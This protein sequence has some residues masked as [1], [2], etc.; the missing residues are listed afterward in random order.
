MNNEIISEASKKTGMALEKLIRVAVYSVGHAT[1]LKHSNNS[2]IVSAKSDC[3]RLTEMFHGWE[4]LPEAYLQ[5][6]L[7]I[8]DLYTRHEKRHGR[9]DL[10][11]F[12]LP[13][14]TAA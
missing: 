5:A 6:V 1:R 2:S 11:Q 13:A 10:L 7:T 9:Q 4:T 8:V 3:K 12:S 14:A